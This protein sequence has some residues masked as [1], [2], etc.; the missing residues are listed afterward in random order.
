MSILDMAR[1]FYDNPVASP[2]SVYAFFESVNMLPA[3]VLDA[4]GEEM[5]LKECSL[6]CGNI[7]GWRYD[8]M[9]EL[10]WV[11]AD[12]ETT[13]WRRDP[14]FLMCPRTGIHQYLQLIWCFTE[15]KT[16]EETYRLTGVRHNQTIQ[17]IWRFCAQKI[18]ERCAQYWTNFERIGSRPG[19]N[20]IEMDEAM[21]RSTK[22]RFVD[23]DPVWI[24]GARCKEYPDRWA[25]RIV[26]NDRTGPN[27]ADFCLTFCEARNTITVNTD[28][29]PGYSWVNQIYIHGVC[30]HK[31]RLLNRTGGVEIN[32]IEGL[33]GE[34]KN[35]ARKLPGGIAKTNH[36]FLVDY[37]TWTK[38]ILPENNARTRFYGLLDMLSA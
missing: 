26:G 24:V 5:E 7:P 38:A 35:V 19:E 32:A 37:F 22:T 14:F 1:V 17:K 27:L 20:T 28:G 2:A 12:G 23:R 29:W 13:S 16:L 33:W 4:D 25:V 11:S 9:H 31:Y 34:M 8:G 18:S 6:P 36:V 3:E 15:S 30:N 21:L 10:E